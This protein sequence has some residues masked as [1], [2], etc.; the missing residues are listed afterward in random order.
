MVIGAVLGF[1][2]FIFGLVLTGSLPSWGAAAVTIVL[3]GTACFLL[4]WRVG[5]GSLRAAA[6]VFAL[7]SGLGVVSAVGQ[8]DRTRRQKLDEPTT[9]ATW[10]PIGTPVKAAPK[11]VQAVAD[12][13]EAEPE[14][15]A[16]TPEE[17]T[18][19]AR[20][21]TAKVVCIG[22]AQDNYTGVDWQWFSNVSVKPLDRSMEVTFEGK[23]ESQPYR[24]VCQIP[25]GYQPTTHTLYRVD[26]KSGKTS[27]ETN[28]LAPCTSNE[29]TATS[30]C[31]PARPASVPVVSPGKRLDEA[32]DQCRD[33]ARSKYPGIEWRT[34]M[35]VGSEWFELLGVHGIRTA[36]EGSRTGQG[37]RI[38]C[39]KPDG[40]VDSGHKLYALHPITGQVT[41]EVVL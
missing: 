27:V 35:G 11:T 28:V 31:R 30:A 22:A 34:I 1:F 4:L 12:P 32:A 37:F 36:M 41:G 16:L 5:P 21:R 33:V 3:G 17:L 23:R 9:A 25:D 18:P 40:A 14:P 24:L 15:E 7:G 2:I 39:F 29:W 20:E 38:V 10:A 8:A 19:E 6:T 13:V 26:P